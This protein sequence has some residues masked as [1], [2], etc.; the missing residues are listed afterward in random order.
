MYNGPTSEA[1][2][3]IRK[4]SPVEF[5]NVVNHMQ[6]RPTEEHTQ[7]YHKLFPPIQEENSQPVH[8]ENSVPSSSNTGVF[9]HL[10][11]PE[12]ETKIVNQPK[13]E[14][15]KEQRTPV[16]LSSSEHDETR[17]PNFRIRGK[18]RTRTRPSTTTEK[19]TTRRVITTA[20]SAARLATNKN[21]EEQEFYGFIRQ[22]NFRTS[23]NQ[24]QVAS[25]THQPEYFTNSN[26]DFNEKDAFYPNHPKDFRISYDNTN[27][28]TTTIRFVGEIKPKYPSTTSRS[29]E[30]LTEATKPS[31]RTRIRT[32]TKK[33]YESS[34][35]KNHR[36]TYSENQES[37]TRRASIIRSRGRTQYKPPPGNQRSKSD[38]E[39]DVEGGNYPRTYLQQKQTSTAATSGFQITIG[40][41]DEQDDEDQ[42]QNSSIY[43]PTIIRPEEW[44]EATRDIQDV[45]GKRSL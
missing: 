6:V 23:T 42:D 40:P 2:L 37:A 16:V 4:S 31:R 35:V 25:A 38:E 14:E 24:I 36:P 13:I 11:N 44:H 27:T 26:Q 34:N 21:S 18:G 1:A 12:I 32:N 29:K 43:R 17:R 45:E 8:Y 39:A 20:T 10:S 9:L 5:E 19:A 33:S 15:I 41:S 7:A 30:A 28:E 22:P 3:E